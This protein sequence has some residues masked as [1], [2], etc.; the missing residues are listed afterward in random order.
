MTLVACHAEGQSSSNTINSVNKNM[1][2]KADILDLATDLMFQF[3][4]AAKPYFVA[5][6]SLWAEETLEEGEELTYLPPLEA[7]KGWNERGIANMTVLSP[8]FKAK[9]QKRAEEG[10]SSGET[11][12]FGC[13]MVGSTAGVG[14]ERFEF[15]VEL[16]ETIQIIENG[17]R[18]TF[19]LNIAADHYHYPAD[20]QVQI[21]CILI[22]EAWLLEDVKMLPY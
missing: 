11:W 3:E 20:A 18:A 6:D 22:G 12:N 17:K 2:S 4:G 13:C 8:Q 14:I 10:M 7:C 1:S 9:V 15:P 5:I 19:N 16:H 21:V